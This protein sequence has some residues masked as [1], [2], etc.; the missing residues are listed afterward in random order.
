MYKPNQYFWAQTDQFLS[1]P[2]VSS[3]LLYE[4]DTVPFLQI[5]LSGCVEVFAEPLNMTSYSREKLLRLVEYGM[6]PSFAVV[7][8]DGPEARPRN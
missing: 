2:A 5:V 8:C 6:A 4:S 7:A 3:Q 1:A